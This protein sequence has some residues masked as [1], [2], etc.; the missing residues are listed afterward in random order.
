MS[1]GFVWDELYGW[2]S[3]KDRS[4]DFWTQ[5]GEEYWENADSKRRIFSLVSATS[6]LKPFLVRVEARDALEE[7]LTY[8]HTPGYV[9]RI[10]TASSSHGLH[11]AVCVCPSS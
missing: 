5:P 2:A 11:E 8:F 4:L 1:V 6:E 10:R 7:E 9:D 3:G